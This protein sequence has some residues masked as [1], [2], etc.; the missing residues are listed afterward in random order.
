MHLVINK[1]DT[2]AASKLLIRLAKVF[3]DIEDIPQPELFHQF[4][5][6]YSG[7]ND[8]D[9]DTNFIFEDLGII[10]RVWALVM[11][12]QPSTSKEKKRL[13]KAIKSLKDALSS[14]SVM[15][16]DVEVFR[17][18]FQHLVISR[19]AKYPLLYVNLQD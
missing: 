5:E 18:T 2:K 1:N 14:A 9:S 16:G 19:R 11:G 8:S 7:P 17:V 15:H 3:D 4:V 6:V 12:L 10:T 13:E